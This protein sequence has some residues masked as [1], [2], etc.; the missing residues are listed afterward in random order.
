MT[1]GRKASAAVAANRARD[2]RIVGR[3]RRRVKGGVGQIKESKVCGGGGGSVDLFEPRVEDL[4]FPV[5]S[6]RTCRRR[7]CYVP[8]S[9]RRARTSMSFGPARCVL[10][11]V[12]GARERGWTGQ[13]GIRGDHTNT[14]REREKRSTGFLPIVHR[15]RGI[16]RT[17]G[18]GYRP[19][20]T[21][22]LLY[23]QQAKAGV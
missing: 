9:L 10:V 8:R 20:G 23:R 7:R 22:A 15:C 12:A 17:G 16:V 14:E 6:P 4:I 18:S 13:C 1:A 19:P 5:S 2:D 3:N 21:V 11:G